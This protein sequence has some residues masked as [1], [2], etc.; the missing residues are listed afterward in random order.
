MS[1]VF[2]HQNEVTGAQGGI[3]RYLSTLIEQARGR[4]LLIT[5]ACSTGESVPVGARIG[6]SLP[7]R[8]AVP[9]WLS[10]V[11]GILVAAPRIRR[12][13]EQVGPC[14]LEFSRPEYALISWMFKGTKVFTI[15]GTGPARSEG[16]KYW[17][18][19]ASCLLLPLAA[20]VVQIVGRDKRGLPSRIST[21]MGTRLRYIDAWYDE[22]FHVTKF[23]SI[24][25][26]L[27]V[28]FAGRLAPMKNPELLFKIVEA[29]NSNPSRNL[30][31]RYFGADADKIPDNLRENGFFSSG[32][33]SAREMAEAI[34]DCH[35]GILCSEYGEGSPFIVVETL[36]SGRG[37]IL[38]PL[39]TLLDAYR[40][41][42]GVIFSE[43][44][45]VDAFIE[46]LRKM[47]TE[48][49]A[50]LSP[51]VIAKSVS[52]RSKNYVAQHVIDC[53]EADHG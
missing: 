11:I 48:I 23:P 8:G 1:L 14:T 39:P 52:N 30:E 37:F 16:T 31:F 36:A 45:S 35:I 51:E 18:H 2:F 53:L 27:R 15:H 10:Y 7:L 34:A 20:D 29:I 3:E 43:A 6:V 46:A 4:S 28:F 47:E 33:L 41:S 12:A 21:L 26:P 32:L 38:P 5:E 13:I 22:I 40:N 19:Y 9:K 25:G 49:R 24:S 17:V 42:P 44:Y 50:G